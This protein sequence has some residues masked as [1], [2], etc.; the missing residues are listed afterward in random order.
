MAIL[1][2]IDDD[3]GARRGGVREEVVDLAE[4]LL[5]VCAQ[6]GRDVNVTARVLEVHR[7]PFRRCRRPEA[8]GG[9]AVLPTAPADA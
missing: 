9:K 6:R 1:D 2:D 3:V 8:D 4:V 5:D 7:L